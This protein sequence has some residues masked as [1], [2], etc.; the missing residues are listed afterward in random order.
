[1]DKPVKHFQKYSS[2]DRANRAASHRMHFRQKQAV[3]EFFWTH[4]FVPGIAFPTRK[5][6]LKAAEQVHIIDRKNAVALP[7]GERTTVNR[8]DYNLAHSVDRIVQC[9]N[10]VWIKAR[11]LTVFADQ[12][13]AVAA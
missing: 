12:P 8:F 2:E 1:M 3:G 5:A 9:D 13:E 4:P 10:G 6:A 11:N 7:D